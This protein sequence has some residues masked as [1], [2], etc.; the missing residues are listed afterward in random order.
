MK[1]VKKQMLIWTDGL[2]Y[3]SSSTDI[4]EDII[5]VRFKVGIER[6]LSG[7]TPR[8]PWLIGNLRTKIWI[9]L[10]DKANEISKNK[11]VL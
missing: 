9:D 5:D 11:N 3:L 7:H 1:S 2:C 6:V 10:K 4:N 8:E